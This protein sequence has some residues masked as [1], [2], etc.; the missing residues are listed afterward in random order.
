[1]NTEQ[2]P[3]V[4]PDGWITVEPIQKSNKHTSST[5][6]GKEVIVVE[7][8]SDVS[9]DLGPFVCVVWLVPHSVQGQ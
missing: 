4:A 7:A 6:K 3:S 2:T 9:K 5:P 1:V 8:V